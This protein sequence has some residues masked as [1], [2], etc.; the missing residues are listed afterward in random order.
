MHTLFPFFFRDMSD[1]HP[2]VPFFLYGGVC[3]FGFAFIFVFLPETHNKT[4]K[5]LFI[6]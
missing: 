5:K 3:A 2:S 1:G 4:V 6:F